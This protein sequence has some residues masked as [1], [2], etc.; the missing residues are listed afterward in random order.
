MRTSPSPAYPWAAAHHLAAL[1]KRHFRQA[2]GVQ[3]QEVDRAGAQTFFI[4]PFT[5]GQAG[6]GGGAVRL[7]KSHLYIVGAA[8]SGNFRFHLG[9]CD[10][11]HILFHHIRR[12]ILDFRANVRFIAFVGNLEVAHAGEAAAH[13]ADFFRGV[14]LF[15][16]GSAAH[17]HNFGDHFT[18][19]GMAGAQEVGPVVPLQQIA[20][21]LARHGCRGWR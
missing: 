5:N 10:L 11:C 4:H 9:V 17:S 16:G 13:R 21:I 15:D 6:F 8:V 18:V 3:R 12:H 7:V 14:C 2:A 20:H 1:H 19:K